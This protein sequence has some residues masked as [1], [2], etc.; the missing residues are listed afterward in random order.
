MKICSLN[1]LRSLI[2]KMTFIFSNSIVLLFKIR[3]FCSIVRNS[4]VFLNFSDFNENLPLSQFEVGDSKN[5]IH[6]FKFYCPIVQNSILL[7]YCSKFY[8]FSKLLPFQWNFALR[9]IWGR[10]FRIWPS[11]FKIILF[12]CPKIQSFVLLFEILLFFKTPPISMKFGPKVNLRPLIS[13]MTS[14]F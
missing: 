1:I 11:F 8:C 7:F 10:W 3:F 14:I 12:Y 13:K 5:D 4:I 9:S 2:P 6:F